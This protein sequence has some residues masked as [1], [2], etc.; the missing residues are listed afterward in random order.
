LV[1]RIDNHFGPQ[2]FPG[3]RL[4]GERGQHK[5]VL[6]TLWVSKIVTHFGPQIPSGFRLKGERGQRKGVLSTLWVSKI[7]AIFGP[8][9]F[10]GFRLQGE[11]GQRKGVSSTLWVSKTDIYSGRQQFS[12]FRLQGERGQRK[13]A[14]STQKKGKSTQATWTTQACVVHAAG[15]FTSLPMEK[16]T[17]D[18]GDPIRKPRSVDNASLRCPRKKKQNAPKQRGQ[19]KLALSTLR[20]ISDHSQWIGEL[21]MLAT[22]LE[23]QTMWTTQA[24]AVDGAKKKTSKHRGL[25]RILSH[26]V[27]KPL[28]LLQKLN[29]HCANIRETWHGHGTSIAQTLYKH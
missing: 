27:R 15:D 18:A 26:M 28:C 17:P 20:V 7:D 24:N 23:S 25:P 19:R 2:Q 13:L 14:L 6:S 29:E 1:S 9:N 21:P 12:G 10:S 4:R 11:R 5:G 22:L 3:F 8:Q 16:G